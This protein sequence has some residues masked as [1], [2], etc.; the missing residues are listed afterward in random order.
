MRGLGF[1]ARQRYSEQERLLRCNAALNEGE[2]EENKF[3]SWRRGLYT[4]QHSP[5]HF[6]SL[7]PTLWQK[8]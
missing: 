2:P 5:N 7:R 4:L 3:K 1:E 8:L 6:A